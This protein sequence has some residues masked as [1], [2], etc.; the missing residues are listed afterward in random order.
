M[1][2]TKEELVKELR[3]NITLQARHFLNE[4]REFYPFGAVINVNY[5]VKP[6]GIYFGQEHPE[7]N[8]VIN[9]LGSALYEGLQKGDYKIVG[10]GID[11]Y[12]PKTDDK[13]TQSAIEIR[14]MN[15][16]GLIAKYWL[17]YYFNQSKKVEF[18]EIIVV[19]E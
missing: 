1:V 14:I 9:K 12:L 17:P 7:S 5:L 15:I 18:K 11:I 19:N 6:V 4:A 13:E 8:D 16:D 10:M 2:P 3:E